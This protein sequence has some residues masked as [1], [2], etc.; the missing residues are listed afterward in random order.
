MK[1]YCLGDSLTYGYGVN[2]GDGWVELVNKS[3]LPFD[4]YNAGINGDTL[5]G[6]RLRLGHKKDWSG[7]EMVTLLGGT[8]DILMGAHFESCY[9][10]YTRICD[11]ILEKGLKPIIMI[12]MEMVYD[13]GQCNEELEK[14]RECLLQYAEDNKFLSIDFHSLFRE[15]MQKGEN[16]MDGD[17]HPNKRGYYL[18]A[19][20]VK[21]KFLSLV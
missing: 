20:L 17:V 15:G 7:F 10:K 13:Y 18:M 4:L 16:L 14:Y 5:E 12:P 6:M 21:N 1:I 8:N 3:D 11:E 19:E 2:Y 9:Q